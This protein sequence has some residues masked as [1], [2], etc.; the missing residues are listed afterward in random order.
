MTVENVTQVLNKVKGDRWRLIDTFGLGI[1]KPLREEIQTRY[2]TD[3]DQIH[4]CIDYYVKNKPG[5]SW[6]HLTDGLYVNKEFAAARKSK[7]FMLT[8]KYCHYITYWYN[9]YAH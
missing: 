3:S 2:T 7:S 9:C 4:G 8:G 1:P 6:E 5:A